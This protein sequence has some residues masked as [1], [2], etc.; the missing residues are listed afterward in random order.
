MNQIYFSIMK[1][2]FHF[3][4]SWVIVSWAWQWESILWCW[5]QSTMRALTDR[6]LDIW[7]WE[8]LEITIDTVAA[9]EA[10]CQKPCLPGTRQH[11][12]TCNTSLNLS[13]G[14]WGQFW[15]QRS[16]TRYYFLIG[17]TYSF[18]FYLILTNTEAFWNTNKFKLSTGV[19]YDPRT[20]VGVKIDPRN[21]FAWLFSWTLTKVK[22]SIYGTCTCNSILMS[23]RLNLL[24]FL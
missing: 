18:I 7:D 12:K 11:N 2:V 19:K 14:S 16:K 21:P 4:W 1:P 15:P 5:I 20:H 22:P 17:W 9:A 8:Q 6:R 23:F 10:D 24:M 13:K 3:V